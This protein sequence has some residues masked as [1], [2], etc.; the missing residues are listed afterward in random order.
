[1]KV[2]SCNC[3]DY[4]EQ[5]GISLETLRG[6]VSEESDVKVT[7]YAIRVKKNGHVRKVWAYYCPICGKKLRYKE[8]IKEKKEDG[9]RS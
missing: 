9:K 6:Y 8:D 4:F 3:F 5:K 2:V 1:M 7:R